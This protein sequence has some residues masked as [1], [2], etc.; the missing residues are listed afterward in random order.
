MAACRSHLGNLKQ[1]KIPAETL[2]L[3]NGL[4]QPLNETSECLSKKLIFLTNLI[5]I[6]SFS[7]T[8][9][10]S[11]RTARR[12]YIGKIKSKPNRFPSI[13]NLFIC[14]KNTF[15]FLHSGKRKPKK[16]CFQI[17]SVQH[18][19]SEDLPMLRCAL[20]KG[21]SFFLEPDLNNAHLL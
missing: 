8:G 19:I 14:T 21:R 13:P 10:L 18:S 7:L 4:V 6:N 12:W 20:F 15:L 3:E 1:I 9:E 5:R 16:F 17:C 11:L 2:Q